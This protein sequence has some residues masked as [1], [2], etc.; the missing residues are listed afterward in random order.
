M[1]AILLPLLLQT[2]AA[3]AAAPQ[4]DPRL[5]ECVELAGS[6]PVTGV[7]RANEWIAANGGSPAWQCLGLAEAGSGRFDRAEAAFTRSAGLAEAASDPNLGNIWMQAG[8]AALA[9]GQGATALVHLDRALATGTLTG[10]ALGEVQLDR[11]RA[12]V[13]ASRP[14]D[15]AAA[16][17]EAVRLAPQDPLGWLLSATLARRMDRLDQAASDIAI[18]AALSPGEPAILLE[19][20]NI[21][22]L[23]GDPGTARAQWRQVA[24]AAPGSP[25]ADAAA[26]QLAALNASA[27]ESGDGAAQA[28]VTPPPTS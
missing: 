19:R 28:G 7:V 11:A 26:Q 2:A 13:A 20:G 9:A 14:D 10:T 8:N 1:I 22:V 25:Q 4:V 24:Q 15:A 27:P 3:P 23:S 12:L 17:K 5:G 18:A 6:D 21:A 16:L